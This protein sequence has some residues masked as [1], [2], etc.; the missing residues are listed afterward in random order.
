MPKV[1]TQVTTPSER[2]SGMNQGLAVSYDRLAGVLAELAQ[3]D[4]AR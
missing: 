2:D 1:E 4:R 3:G